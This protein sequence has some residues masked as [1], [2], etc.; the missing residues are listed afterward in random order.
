[1]SNNAPD[2]EDNLVFCKEKSKNKDWM[3]KDFT[4]LLMPEFITT[5][6]ECWNNINKA[7]I[8]LN[9]LKKYQIKCVDKLAQIRKEKVIIREWSYDN[10]IT[11]DYYVAK[12]INNLNVDNLI[13]D[14]LI[15]YG[16]G[17]STA[18]IEVLKD[19]SHE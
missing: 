9:E 11:Y 6:E 2:Y 12:D 15:D 18:N 8:T 10:V 13:C 7:Q 17:Y 5:E 4:D 1:M 14:D 19:Y 16:D 3:I